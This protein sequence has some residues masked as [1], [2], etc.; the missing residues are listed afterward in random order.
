[1][2]PGPE[3]NFQVISRKSGG[4]RWWV[5]SAAPDEK[6]NTVLENPDAFLADPARQFKSSRNVTIARIPREEKTGWVLRRLNYGKLLHRL[7]DFFRP[8]RAHRAFWSG[9][10][11][12][13]EGVA[14][15]R[16][17]AV[18]EVRQLGWPMRAYLLTE[19]ISE[20][21][22]L[23]QLCLSA[24]LLPAG[25]EI[26]L[27]DLLARLHNLALS[28]RD[29]KASN[30]LIDL[31]GQPCL[32]DLDGV[33]RV[34]FGHRS[35]AVADLARLARDVVGGP[36]VT[37]KLLIRFLRAY[38]QDRGVEDWRAWWRQIE[39]QLSPD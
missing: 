30:V 12:E 25:L 38:C 3:K 4:L 33:R 21:R 8:S 20:A 15:A 11:L 17:L 31:Q 28:H 9:L 22:T 16:V 27:A 26:R 19:E 13:K 1:M 39:Q 36:C 5:R 10:R 6:L 29:L 2:K 37:L 23:A 18:C 34:W 35:R 14:T 7:R 24:A 32:I